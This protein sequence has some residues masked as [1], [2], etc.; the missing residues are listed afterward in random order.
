M[1]ILARNVYRFSISKFNSSKDYYK[2]LG[3]SQ[4]S[5]EKE[6]KKAF[7]DLAKKYHPDSGTGNEEKFK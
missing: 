1:N 4:G 7:R 3:V 2:I 6:V 5:N